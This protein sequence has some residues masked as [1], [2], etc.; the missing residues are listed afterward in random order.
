MHLELELHNLRSRLRMFCGVRQHHGARLPCK[1]GSFPL[2]HQQEWWC[3]LNNKTFR[4][5]SAG[6]VTR[7]HNAI[8]PWHG[9]GLRHVEVD[10]HCLRPWDL[11]V[12][13]IEATLGFRYVICVSDITR[14]LSH[15]LKLGRRLAYKVPAR[16]VPR[17]VVFWDGPKNILRSLLRWAA[18]TRL[19]HPQGWRIRPG[20]CKNMEELIEIGQSQ[21]LL[22]VILRP[23]RLLRKCLKRLLERIPSLQSS[24]DF[25]RLQRTDRSSASPI[26]ALLWVRWPWS[27]PSGA[28]CTKDQPSASDEIGIHLHSEGAVHN[29]MGILW[30]VCDLEG[31]K[32]LTSTQEGH[33]D[34]L[35]HSVLWQLISAR[36]E[37]MQW[38]LL[39][40]C[41]V[42]QHR[43]C[44]TDPGEDSGHVRLEAL[45]LGHD[46]VPSD[47]A[48]VADTIPRNTGCMFDQ[49]WQ[50]SLAWLIRL[51][52]IFESLDERIDGHSRT[53]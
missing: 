44:R 36:K 51:R 18:R 29:S 22:I 24:N 32:D 10:E 53:E 9:K 14:C 35:E 31:A 46:E 27:S 52:G 6:D 34:R 28:K 30:P 12:G 17:L 15:A 1:L 41:L 50:R 21:V 40:L 5:I 26:W 37:F 16:C 48:K 4:A 20:S 23:P 3:R 45:L 19:S 25:L 39:L 47:G 42:L 13:R 2:R 49:R 38:D 43:G 33:R 11:H 8:N 7:I